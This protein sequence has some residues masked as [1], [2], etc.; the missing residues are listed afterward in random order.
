[1][2]D[3]KQ[4][5]KVGFLDLAIKLGQQKDGPNHAPYYIKKMGL[6]KVVNAC[7]F[8]TFYGPRIYGDGVNVFSEIYQESKALMNKCDFPIFLGGDH[9]VSYSTIAAVKDKFKNVGVIWVDAH[10][11]MNTTDT[12]PTGNLHGMPVAGLLGLMDTLPVFGMKRQHAILKPNDIVYIG[13]RDIDEGEKVFLRR[14]G[15][16][17]FTAAKVRKLGINKV[18]I[19]SFTHFLSRGYKNVHLSFDVDSVDPKY[20]RATGTPVAGGLTLEDLRLMA[21]YLAVSKMLCSMDIVEFNPLIADKHET[22]KT[23]QLIEDFVKNYF[24]IRKYWEQSVTGHHFFGR[25]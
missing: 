14:L 20:A 23:Y 25:C 10:A 5:T 21:E 7:G 13:L 1:M 17:Y 12:S 2:F 24:E 9:S 6:H 19:E 18:L 8:D 3:L 11:D 4:K 16:K 22:I 15:I